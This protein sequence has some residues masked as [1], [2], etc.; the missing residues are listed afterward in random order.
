MKDRI[1][2]YLNTFA[3]GQHNEL[4]EELKETLHL[5]NATFQQY[6]QEAQAA[7]LHKYDQFSIS[8]I[9]A[10]FQKVIR[11]FTREAGLVGD[12]R[13]EVETDAVLEEVIDNLMD[14]LGNNKELTD[15]VVEFAKENLENERPWDV[16]SNLI[17]F[18]SEIFREEFKEIEDEVINTT[19]SRKYFH[20]LRKVLLNERDHFLSTG[21]ALAKKAI[22]IFEEEGWTEADIKYGK[23]SGLF[24]FL[25]KYAF[26]KTIKAKPEASDRVKEFWSQQTGR[27]P[28]QRALNE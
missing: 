28:K 7:I 18:A 19:S 14:E 12:Y 3:R 13:L 23:G 2:E 4:T 17:E 5:D 20:D 26:D 6:A 1:L 22:S 10:F 21:E 8:T 15:W 9:D 25:Q 24:G 27:A 16:R 11:S